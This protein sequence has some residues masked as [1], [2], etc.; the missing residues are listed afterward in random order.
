M[1]APVRLD[2]ESAAGA[3]IRI[4]L[5]VKLLAASVLVFALFTCALTW[6]ATA[7]LDADLATAFQSKGEAI[8][9]AMAAAA[10][11]SAKGDPLILQNSIEANRRQ[12]GVAYIFALDASGRSFGSTFL[13]PIPDELIGKNQ[14]VPGANVAADTVVAAD[15]DYSG[16]EHRE[17][18]IDV[19]A[20]IARATLGT[21]HVG[22]DR[23]LIDDEVRSLQ[24]RLLLSGA[25]VGAVGAAALFFS[26]L[27]LVIRPVN[28]LTRVTTEIVRR[29]DLTQVIRIR[30]SDEIGTLATTFTLM[31]DKLR[32]IPRGVRE[33]TQLLAS[34]VSKLSDST[35]EQS[36]TV[37]KQAAAL[38]ETQVTAQEIRQT[39][40]LASQKAEAVLQYAERGDV[41]SRTGESAVLQSV[42]ALTAI[43]AQVEE[44][45]ERISRLG[46][47]TVQIGKVTQTV[48]DL[49]DQTNMLALNAAIEAVR[50][51]EHG[52][53]FA[54]VA[55]EM[56][57]LADQS[58]QGTKQV[59]EMIED[60]SAAIREAV[61]ITDK[62]VQ[63]IDSGLAEVKTSGDTLAELSRIVK[64]NSAAV[65]QISAAVGQQNAG[66]SQIFGAVSDQSKMMDDTVTRLAATDE[67][68]QTLRAASEKLV[69]IV[70]QFK[71]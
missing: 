55:R 56:R 69:Q 31:V 26:I 33:S 66:I 7:Q 54:V 17:H 49:A 11:R 47:R 27:W 67:S 1:A 61:V 29:G 9:L 13:G 53:G 43:R 48:K 45:A 40:I 15:L 63:R 39:S 37:T 30:S 16:P 6:R 52:K 36:H 50:S 59:R 8:A 28:E 34:S 14:L 44:I 38:Q 32:E 46:E 18:A 10:E 19:V 70:E 4:G 68:V 3:A 20:P 71:V 25:V 21:V 42:A 22:M 24:N 58:L 2:K 65:R 35:A 41:L 51:G 60:I 57:S 23:D 12:H 62:G 64:D 5:A